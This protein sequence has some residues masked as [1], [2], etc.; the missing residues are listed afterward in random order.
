[1]GPSDAQEQHLR[2]DTSDSSK[3]SHEHFLP[4]H[5][6]RSHEAMHDKKGGRRQESSRST[7]AHRSAILEGLENDNQGK[8]NHE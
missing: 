4:R 6:A 8:F 3:T 5:C 1:M 7:Q 2:S